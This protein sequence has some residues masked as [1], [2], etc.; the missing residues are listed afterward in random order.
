M[1]ATITPIPT[2]RV[3][4]DVNLRDE[5]VLEDVTAWL[6]ANPA[7][8]TVGTGTGGPVRGSGVEVWLRDAT[9]GDSTKRRRVNRR[10]PQG[11][12]YTRA[13]VDHLARTV[14]VEK[15]GED[16][17][18]KGPAR[19]RGGQVEQE[20]D[21]LDME[22]RYWSFME[23]HP[24][25]ASL[26]IKSK[27]EALEV[28]TWAKTDHLLPSQKPV[29]APFTPE[30]C[31]ELMTLLKSFTPNAPDDNGIETRVVARVL[32]R[33]AIWRQ[34]YFRSHKPLPKDVKTP[35]STSSSYLATETGKSVSKAVWDM[36]VVV[37]CLGLPYIFVENRR[38]RMDHEHGWASGGSSRSATPAFIVGIISC[39]VAAIILSASV[40]FI[41]LP[42][43]DGAARI[44]G[45]VAIA[46]A[47]GSMLA[48]VVS[49]IIFRSDLSGFA[50]RPGVD[51]STGFVGMEGLV[52]ISVSSFPPSTLPCITRADSNLVVCPS[53]REKPL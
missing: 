38:Q 49:F 53:Y 6:D 37:V 47:I 8:R 2:L 11:G 24:A 48:S 52:G 12:R 17:K 30:E 39:L 31:Q 4:T 45:F 10:A 18:G 7:V 25:H 3:T 22:Y 28:L 27:N 5:K 43:M 26:P 15:I 29:P 40:T 23:A 33:V 36:F 51:G 46:C 32:L 50:D 42:A 44:A 34:K 13:W 21:Q 1:G 16:R 20:E 35:P 14:V 19:R 9:P 41:S